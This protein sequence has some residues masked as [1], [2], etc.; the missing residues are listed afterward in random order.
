MLSMIAI[1]DAPTAVGS[2]ALLGLS[3]RLQSP[4]F[5]NLLLIFIGPEIKRCLFRNRRRAART[6]AAIV[7]INGIA[8]CTVKTFLV[9]AVSILQPQKIDNDHRGNGDNQTEHYGNKR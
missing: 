3:G 6:T 7:L 4:T 9:I 5:D 1:M 8:L 2:S